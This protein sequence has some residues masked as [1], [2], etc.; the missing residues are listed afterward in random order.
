[1]TH[2]QTGDTDIN[3]SSWK[4]KEIDNI[5]E[6]IITYTHPLNILFYPS[7]C[8]NEQ[9]QTLQ[10]FGDAGFCVMSSTITADLAIADSFRLQEYLLVS[11][12]DEGGISISIVFYVCFLKSTFLHGVITK[13]SINDSLKFHDQFMTN[14]KHQICK[15]NTKSTNDPSKVEWDAN[16]YKIEEKAYS[17]KVTVVSDIFNNRL[18][19]LQRTCTINQYINFP[20][21]Y[22]V[23]EYLIQLH[24]CS[25]L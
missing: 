14:V 6:R 2:E 17:N 23:T 25:I 20:P 15:L 12:N 1:M 4:S 10:R 22:F 3:I 24:T 19:S 13:T 8:R 18:L 9:T 16:L 7:S 11:S 21:S 5:M